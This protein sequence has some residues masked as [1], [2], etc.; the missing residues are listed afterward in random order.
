M[1]ISSYRP[2]SKCIGASKVGPIHTTHEI[3]NTVPKV[4][5]WGENLTGMAGGKFK[6]FETHF[7][8]K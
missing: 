3:L 8:I 5:Y 7:R 1:T 4:D 6:D 2:K